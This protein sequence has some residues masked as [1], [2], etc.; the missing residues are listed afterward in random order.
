MQTPRSISSCSKALVLE[1]SFTSKAVFS[2]GVCT[3]ETLLTAQILVDKDRFFLTVFNSFLL[4]LY[5]IDNEVI[6]EYKQLVQIP[7]IFSL[8]SNQ[9]DEIVK[10]KSGFGIFTYKLWIKKKFWLKS[11]CGCLYDHK[12]VCIYLMMI[13]I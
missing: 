11:V 5:S 7:S 2:D 13:R 1:M 9:E 12:F 10:L 8:F 3:V 6:D 4:F